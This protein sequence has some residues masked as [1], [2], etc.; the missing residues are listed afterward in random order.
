MWAVSSTQENRF[1]LSKTKHIIQLRYFVWSRFSFPTF[2]LFCYCLFVFKNYFD[3]FQ[4]IEWMEW[5]NQHTYTYTQNLC[6]NS[7]S[8]FSDPL[9]HWQKKKTYCFLSLTNLLVTFIFALSYNPNT[10]ASLAAFEWVELIWFRFD[11]I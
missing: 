9:I 4:Q 8:L 2:F 7:R 11:T 6:Y 1:I 5:E 3:L 10:I